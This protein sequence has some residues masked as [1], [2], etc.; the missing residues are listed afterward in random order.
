MKACGWLVVLYLFSVLGGA[1][2]QDTKARSNAAVVAPKATPTRNTAASVTPAPQVRRPLITTNL[3]ARDMEFLQNLVANGALS[4]W[5]G[6]LAKTR[7]ETDQV[8]A[9][10]DALQSTQEEENKH[11]SILAAQKG[12][13]AENAQKESPRQKKLASEFEKLEGLKFDKACMQAMLEATQKA[14][15]S[16]EAGTKSQDKDIRSFA[17]QMLPIAREKMELAS[18]VAGRS[19]ADGPKRLFR[20]T[21]PQIQPIGEAIAPPK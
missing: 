21:S 2:A 14:V 3:G 15:G 20:G 16:Y 9:V 10:G 18:K 6:G 4:A 17:E 5:L 13:P 7:A 8:R 11:L 19:A 1:A 12:L